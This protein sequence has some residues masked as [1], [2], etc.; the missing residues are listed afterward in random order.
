MGFVFG[1]GDVFVG[2]QSDKVSFA[3][4]HREL[5]DFMALQNLRCFLEVGRLRGGD[6]V[7]RG[8]HF[9]DGTVE[10]AFETEVAVGD[11]TYQEVFFIDHGYAADVEFLHHF[12]GVANGAAPAYG[13]RVVNHPVFGAFHRMHLPRLLLYGHVLVNH[14]DAAFACYGYGHRCLCHGVHRGRHERHIQGDVS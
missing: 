12:Q 14:A 13:H 1:L 8:H 7:F 11:Y 9:V 3:V 6:D 2:Y 4:N 10:V 5:F